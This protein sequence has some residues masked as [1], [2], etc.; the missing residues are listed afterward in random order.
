MSG[1]VDSSV[2]AALM[3]E[4]GHEVVGVTLKLWAG[5]NGEVP[6]AWLLH[7]F[8][9]RGCT[10]GRSQLDIPCTTYSASPTNSLMVWSTAS[11]GTTALVE[12]ELTIRCNR[13][14]KFDRLLN[15]LADFD[16]EVLVTGHHAR[17]TSSS[18][19]F[20]AAAAQTR[21]AWSILLSLVLT[22]PS[23]RGSQAARG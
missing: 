21:T 18:A 10:P 2:A 3:R 1:G 5:P 20:L 11:C 6:T 7:R 23:S 12:L 14:I 16:S 8:R 4:A 22:E 19:A 9:C 17:R 13:T 15:R